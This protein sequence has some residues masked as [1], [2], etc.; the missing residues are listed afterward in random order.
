M[1][2]LDERVELEE[3]IE[4]LKTAL[5]DASVQLK[6]VEKA[7]QRINAAINECYS[8]VGRDKTKMLCFAA[9]FEAALNVLD[10]ELEK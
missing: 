7:K 3:Q 5:H 9:A 6:K 4:D 10:E 2:E 8:R 1:D